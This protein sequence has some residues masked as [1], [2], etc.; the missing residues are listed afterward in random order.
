[1]RGGVEK[2][3]YKLGRV[4]EKLPPGALGLG[5]PDRCHHLLPPLRSKPPPRR[6]SRRG[7]E[8]AT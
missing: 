3:A 4:L 6:T 7:G 2:E 1:M 5:H 8:A